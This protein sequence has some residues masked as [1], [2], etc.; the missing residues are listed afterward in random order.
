[1]LFGL[2]RASRIAEDLQREFPEISLHPN[3]HRLRSFSKPRSLPLAGLALIASWLH[4]IVSDFLI[5][6]GRSSPATQSP[7]IRL[8]PGRTER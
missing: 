6:D 7:L 5:I 1:M 3:W 8:R 2:F 4:K